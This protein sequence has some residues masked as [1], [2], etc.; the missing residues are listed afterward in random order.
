MTTNNMTE[1]PFSANWRMYM[2]SEAFQFTVRGT[3]MEKFVVQLNTT[4]ARL[5][6]EGWQMID[7]LATNGVLPPVN[8]TVA[9][10]HAAQHSNASLP[11]AGTGVSPAFK[12]QTIEGYVT[13]SMLDRYG[14]KQIVVW[15]YV[16]GLNYKWQT[17]YPERHELLPFPYPTESSWS[18]N[19][20]NKAQAI[21]EGVYVTKSFQV[22]SVPERN[23]DGSLKVNAKGYQTYRLPNRDEVKSAETGSK[24]KVER[25]KDKDSLNED[26]FLWSMGNHIETAARYQIPSPEDQWYADQRENLFGPILVNGK[27]S[28]QQQFDLLNDWVATVAMEGSNINSNTKLNVNEGVGEVSLASFVMGLM[29]DVFVSSPDQMPMEA[30]VAMLQNVMPMR[31]TSPNPMYS[32]EFA[33]NMAT[34]VYAAIETIVSKTA[35]PF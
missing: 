34:I 19:A 3:D 22:L 8:K 1:A 27:G 31:G 26:E 28:T 32:P 7:D 15:L 30:T 16:P 17:V 18:G 12:L 2:N 6:A 20:P 25:R 10:Q 35:A 33:E 29:T 14:N 23:E 9:A 5:K 21:A 4:V 24:P 11:Q 13:G